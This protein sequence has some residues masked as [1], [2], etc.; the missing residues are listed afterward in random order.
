M[1]CTAGLTDL[2]RDGRAGAEAGIQQPSGLQAIK[3][4]R[5]LRH[6][7]GLHAY[8]S[9]PRQAQEVQIVDQRIGEFGATARAI[10]VFDAQQKPPAH[11]VC[12]GPG[13]PRRIGVPNVQISRRRWRKAADRDRGRSVI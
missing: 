11:V 4:L 13:D 5:V 12:S 8:G 10:D 9:V 2:G 1:W 3:H 7:L 6:M